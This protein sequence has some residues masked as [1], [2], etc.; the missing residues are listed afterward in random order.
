[1]LLIFGVLVSRV[2]VSVVEKTGISLRYIVSS[3]HIENAGVSSFLRFFPGAVYPLPITHLEQAHTS[4]RSFRIFQFVICIPIST[5]SSVLLTSAW[6]F[7][8]NTPLGVRSSK[9]FLSLKAQTTCFKELFF[10]L[11]FGATGTIF[12]APSSGCSIHTF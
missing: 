12:D 2:F 4:H 6:S 7:W 8:R 3:P 9:P 1:M 10:R 5:I 11:T